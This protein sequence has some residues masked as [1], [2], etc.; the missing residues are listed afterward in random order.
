MSGFREWLRRVTGLSI[1]VNFNAPT[2]LN[3]GR[4]KRDKDR[5]IPTL[6]GNAQQAQRRRP[7]RIELAPART[8]LLTQ[9]PDPRIRASL[10]EIT[11]DLATPRK[12]HI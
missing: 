6:L 4:G 7:L 2:V 10:A 3:F 1:T 9:P 12:Y 5:H 11:K 8:R